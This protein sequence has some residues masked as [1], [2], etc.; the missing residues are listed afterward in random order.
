MKALIL[1]AGL[2]S[3]LKHRTED[4]PKALTIVCGKPILSYQIEVLLEEGIRDITIVIGYKGE[5]IIEYLSSNYVQTY[6]TDLNFIG[7]KRRRLI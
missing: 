5:K 2:G 6:D 4:R 3:R 7:Y 1:A